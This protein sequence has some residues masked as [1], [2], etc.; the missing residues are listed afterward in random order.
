MPSGIPAD[1]S[2]IARARRRYRH[3]PGHAHFDA[4]R[5]AVVIDHLTV[6]DKDVVREAQRWTTGERGAVVDDPA[7]LDAADLGEF[8]SEAVKIGAHALS[9][10]GQA[11]DSRALERMLKEVGEKAAT[12]SSQAAEHTARTVKQATTAVTKAAEDAKKAITEADGASRQEFTKSVAAAKKDLTAG[13]AH[14]Y[15]RRC[16]LEEGRRRALDQR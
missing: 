12:S 1:T 10:T 15:R 11:Q 4:D 9:A 8:V 7:V 16:A 14:H 5:L 3:V 6:R 2:E 13:P